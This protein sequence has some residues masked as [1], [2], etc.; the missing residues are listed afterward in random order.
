LIVYKNESYN[1]IIFAYFLPF[2]D[3]I[4]F[5]A[6]GIFSCLRVERDLYA[7]SAPGAD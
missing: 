1:Y 3:G 4:A 5:G 6:A 7:S 2:C